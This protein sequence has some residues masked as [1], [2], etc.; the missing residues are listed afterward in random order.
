M[1]DLEIVEKIPEKRKP[2]WYTGVTSPNWGGRRKG[3]GR[4]KKEEGIPVR[5]EFNPIQQRL[6]IEYG[7]GDLKRGIER[8]INENF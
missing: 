6:L 2:W 5:L 1:L 7:G 8:L 4:P 3:A